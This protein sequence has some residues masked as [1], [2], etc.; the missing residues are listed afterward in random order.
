MDRARAVLQEVRPLPTLAAITAG[1][2][3]MAIGG[4]LDGWLAYALLLLAI[5]YLAHVKDAYVDYYVRREDQEYPWGSSPPTGE[6]VSE[7]GLA[8]M[9]AGAAVVVVAVPATL[10]LGEPLLFYGLVVAMVALAASYAGRLDALPLGSAFSYPVG[11]GLATVAGSVLAAGRVVPEALLYAGPLVVV[12]AGAKVVEDIID[13]GHDAEL[14]KRT[15]P[16]ALGPGRARRLG[17][18]VVALGML[19]WVLW[20][21]RIAVAVVAGL[22]VAAGTSMMEV[23]RGIYPLVAG[24]YVAMAGILVS[25]VF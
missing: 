12:L 21:G 25:A 18:G 23:D 7:R 24:I 15:V 14:G 17:L 8:A 9:A 1:V 16:V 2:T 5:L 20:D 11:V 19:P 22:A 4:S 6:L 3:G 10:L 13:V